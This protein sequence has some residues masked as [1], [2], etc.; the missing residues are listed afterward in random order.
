MYCNVIPVQGNVV[1]THLV[2]LYTQYVSYHLPISEFG[3]S[4]VVDQFVDSLVT[5]RRGDGS[6]VTST[7]SA[8]PALLHTYVQAKKWDDALKLARFVKVTSTLLRK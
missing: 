5:V 2:L 1:S 7:V 6:L 4:G 8:Y 3:K